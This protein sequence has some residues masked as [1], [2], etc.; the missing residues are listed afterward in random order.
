MPVMSLFLNLYLLMIKLPS[1]RLKGIR[2]E[3]FMLLRPY[4][5][6][7]FSCILLVSAF[8]AMMSGDTIEDKDFIHYGKVVSADST[9]VTYF[10]ACKDSSIKL[11][12]DRIWAIRFDDN[13]DPSEF[14][15]PRAPITLP[16]KTKLVYTVSIKNQQDMVHAEK[17][18]LND[19]VFRIT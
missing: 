13:C 12:W 5:R 17:L 10:P 15:A 3:M 8:N 1:P 4:H 11:P 6:L 16:C 9:G 14:K 19:H 7:A 2:E 18:L